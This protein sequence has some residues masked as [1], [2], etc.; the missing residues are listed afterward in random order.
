MINDGRNGRD[1]KAGFYEY[2]RGT[3]NRKI[4][5]ELNTDQKTPQYDAAE[6]TERLLFVQVL[7]ALWCLHEGV[8]NTVAEANFGSVQGWGF[9]S[10]RGG[11]FQYVNDY[12]ISAF[13]E[14]CAIYEKMHGQRFKVPKFLK[15]LIDLR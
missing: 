7:E 14:K 1:V 5:H 6:I 12:G 8:I 4:W 15:K 2:E 9:P 11:V 10:V 13:V 3:N